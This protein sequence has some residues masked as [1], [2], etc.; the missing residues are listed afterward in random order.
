MKHQQTQNAYA[1]CHRMH[2]LNRVWTFSNQIDL[3]LF[4]IYIKTIISIIKW[5]NKTIDKVKQTRHGD[6]GLTQ[7]P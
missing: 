6:G 7:N 5:I 1:R 4:M 2:Q 3:E